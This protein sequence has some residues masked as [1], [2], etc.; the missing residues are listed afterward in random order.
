VEH[1]E[2]MGETKNPYVILVGKSEWKKSLER[3]RHEG[4]VILLLFHL[5][6]LI[7]YSYCH[8]IE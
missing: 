8:G 3:T 2:R 4:R 6:E 5:M 7:L 1:A